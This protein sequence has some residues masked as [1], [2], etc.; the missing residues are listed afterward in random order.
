M[1]HASAP[2]YQGVLRSVSGDGKE[3]RESYF[4]KTLQDDSRNAMGA[5]KSC[6][7][8]KPG[9][10]RYQYQELPSRTAFRIL[11][12]LPG[13][14][15]DQISFQLQNVDW[16]I[17]TPYEAVSYAWGDAKSKAMSTCDGQDFMITNNL[18]DG[19]HAMRHGSQSRF[20]WADAICI[21]Q[22]NSEERGRQVK[23]MGNIYR[24][25]A[26]VLVWLGGD[27]DGQGRR[28]IMAMKEIA[29]KCLGR[30]VEDLSDHEPNLRAEHELW[31]LLPEHILQ[32]LDCD[33]EDSWKAMS[34][35]FS[36]PWFSRLWVIQEVVSN[37]NVEVLCGDSCVSW[38][39][40]ALTA[41]YIRRHADTNSHWGMGTSFVENAYYMR[42]RFWL[43]RVSL[44]S[45]LN[46]GRSFNATDSL[47]RV[48]GFMA[49]PSFTNSGLGWEAG[50]SRSKVELY[51]DVAYHC[52]S[53]T[54]SFRVLCY[55]QH[56]DEDNTFPSWVPQWDRKECY[57]A[58]DD[59][60]T[61]VQWNSSADTKISSQVDL[62]AGVLGLSGVMVDIITSSRP[63]AYNMESHKGQVSRNHPCLDFLESQRHNLSAYCTGETQLEAFSHV[64][65]VGLNVNRRKASET[66]GEVYAHFNS[67][68]NH[69]LEA[70]GQVPPR[71]ESLSNADENINKIVDWRQY[72]AL[73]QRQCRNR[74]LFF[75]RKGYIGL[76]PNVQPGD[77]VCIFFGG[78]VPFIL[79]PR[80]SYYELIGDA[81]VHGIM[82]G[83]I[84]KE[85]YDGA[86]A[87]TD[88][89]IH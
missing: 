29:A 24:G 15:D 31:D 17:S 74:S 2:G 52:I 59:S 84:I 36:R 48:Y 9:S 56:S 16:N 42:R 82:E 89:E 23:H 65:A 21:D 77:L 57:K 51:K 81:Y 88:F 46:W 19:L 69:L 61:K 71:V 47:D 54:H 67:Y 60:L 35:F 64:I 40:V 79:R 14:E 66:P 87:K 78:E 27:E 3:H 32:G 22:S 37:R 45:L 70:T 55:C 34:W 8:R 10:S 63:L 68:I 6:L 83:E 62:E 30:T 73:I 53:K 85:Y 20:L 44:P 1:G 43:E 28:A 12:L 49:M 33:N 38:D 50:Y 7:A 13:N 26:K 80:Q 5:F 76:G 75:T 72:E 25:A 86:H 11:E 39:V 18:H 58:I 41:S 4:C